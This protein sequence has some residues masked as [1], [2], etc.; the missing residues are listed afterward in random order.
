M[1][2]RIAEVARDNMRTMNG[3][4][5]FMLQKALD[6]RGDEHDNRNT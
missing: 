5:N 1:R 4:I 3:Q 6:A 2:N